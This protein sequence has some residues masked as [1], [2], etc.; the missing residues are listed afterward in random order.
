VDGPVE[1]SPPDLI[2]GLCKYSTFCRW[3]STGNFA[4]AFGRLRGNGLYLGRSC[5]PG[6]FM[7]APWRSPAD[8]LRRPDKWTGPPGLLRAP[9]QRLFAGL[10]E[11]KYSNTYKTNSNVV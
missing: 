10:L 9:I 7:F 2:I 6:K 5:D 11:Y 3:F 8:G 1:P 4:S